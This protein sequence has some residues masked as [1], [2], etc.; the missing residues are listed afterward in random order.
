MERVHVFADESG[1]FDFSR[2]QGASRYFI[3]TTV[4]CEYEVGNALLDLRREL[5]WNGHGHTSEFHATDDSLPVRARVF[6]LLQT[7]DFRVDA[8]ILEKSKAQPQTRVSEETFYQYAW[9]YHMRRLVPLVSRPGDELFVVGASLGTK[10][11]RKL[12]HQAVSNVVAQV[13]PRAT[14]RTA[15]WAADSEPCLQVADYCCWAISR[16]WERGIRAEFDLIAP[17]VC[18]EFDLWARGNTHYY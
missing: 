3:L 7:L 12:M 8:T 9:Y 11:K 15:F 16:K 17:R 6:D 18:S 13:A 1:N 5:A 4:V 14:Y 2:K 10:K